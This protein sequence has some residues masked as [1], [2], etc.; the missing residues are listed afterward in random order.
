MSQYSVSELQ[1][2]VWLNEYNI[3]GILLERRGSSVLV[4]WILSYVQG[5]AKITKDFD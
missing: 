5:C 2:T 1:N 4:K 3:Y